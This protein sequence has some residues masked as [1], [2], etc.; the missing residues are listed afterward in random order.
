MNFLR[1]SRIYIY[2]ENNLLQNLINAFSSNGSQKQSEPQVPLY[3]AEAYSNL[4]QPPQ[5][6]NQNALLPLLLSLFGQNSPDF[7][8]ILSG[9]NGDLS[10]LLSLIST[11][12]KKKEEKKDEKKEV[13]V[14]DSDGLL[15]KDE[16]L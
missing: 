15:P 13:I 3:P 10:S 6:N 9:Q 2:M 5:T 12:S 8:N 4:Q 16:L 14:Q 1:A 11:L 7:S